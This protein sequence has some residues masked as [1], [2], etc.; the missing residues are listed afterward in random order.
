MFNKNKDR[1]YLCLY[2]RGGKVKMASSEDRWVPSVPSL[3]S[4]TP[5]LL[6]TET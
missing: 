6:P 5:S 3:H 2:T 1:L 4:V